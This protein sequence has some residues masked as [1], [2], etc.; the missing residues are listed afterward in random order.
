MGY[1]TTPPPLTPSQAATEALRR[2]E[3]APGGRVDRG[4]VDPDLERRLGYP[5]LAAAHPSAIAW[6]TAAKRSRDVAA[7]RKVE[8]D[9]RRNRAYG[10]TYGLVLAGLVVVADLGGAPGLL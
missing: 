6:E 10:I 7:A 4:R 2:L 1:R 5:E 3:G 8:S 9:R